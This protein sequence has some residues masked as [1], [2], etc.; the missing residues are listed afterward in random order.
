MSTVRRR[1]LS[2]GVAG[3][4]AYISYQKMSVATYFKLLDYSRFGIINL[5]LVS[6]YYSSKFV[7]WVVFGELRPTEIQNL[8]DSLF[9]T[10]YEFILGLIM[11]RVLNGDVFDWNQALKYGGFF[12][13]VLLLK[14]FHYLTMDRVRNIFPMYKHSGRNLTLLHLR[15]AM[16]I[17]LLHYVDV[18]LMI[19][20]FREIFFNSKQMD[21]L[22]L[23]FGFEV[24]NL[25]P[26]IV[27]TSIT[28]L[29]NYL[30][31]R[32]QSPS[33]YGDDYRS[34]LKER[35][36][37]LVDVIVNIIRLG[38][39]ILFSSL[40]VTFFTIPALHVLPSLYICLR[41]LIGRT[42]RLIWLQ[43]NAIKLVHINNELEDTDLSLMT[44]VDNKC[45]ICLDRL[46]SPNRTAKKLRC[47]HTFHSICIQ[48]WM[49]VSRN[50]PVCR[51]KG[52]DTVVR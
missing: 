16:G 47:D 10:S 9:Y 17:V 12:L 28:Y 43:K 7:K 15:F 27:Y 4:V 34:D 6:S 24:F 14:S 33:R 44:K 51:Y 49:L 48:S 18:V 32:R 22:V 21:L 40:F 46:D 31:F 36:F 35:I 3:T 20:F 29:G 52:K 37:H 13:S 39:F 30:E 38:M 42:R 5:I 23:I 8:K 1:S 11:V 26:L 45:V 50:C 25:H 2:V 41:Q 19:Q